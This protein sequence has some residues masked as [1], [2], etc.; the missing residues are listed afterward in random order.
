MAV[1]SSGVIG[2]GRESQQPAGTSRGRSPT[3]HVHGSSSQGL[4]DQEITTTVTHASSDVKQKGW[5]ISSTRSGQSR[6]R[7]RGRSSSKRPQP[8]VQ[9]SSNPKTTPA[10]S[11]A[12]VARL[13]AKGYNLSYIPPTFVDNK[14]IVRLSE[15]AMEASNP[16]WNEYLVGY[17]V[18]RTLPYRITENSLKFTWGPKL[19]EVLAD[20]QEFYYFHIPDPTFRRKI[21]EDGPLTVA[22]VP[23]ILKQWKP[24]ME[25]KK[26]KQESIPVW[27]RLKNL[28]F[29]LWSAHSISAIA[30]VVGKPLYVDERTEQRK[31]ISFARVCV[32]LHAG[33]PSC[34]SV[35]VVLEGVVRTIAIVYEWKPMECGRCGCFGHNCDAPPPNIRAGRPVQ[36]SQNAPPST[37]AGPSHA[38]DPTP[39]VQSHVPVLVVDPKE[40]QHEI[41]QVLQSPVEAEVEVVPHQD[42]NEVKG[43]KKKKKKKKTA[44]PKEGS[45]SLHNSSGD[46]GIQ[47]AAKTSASGKP[48]PPVSSRK[49]SK[50][51]TTPLKVVL[52]LFSPEPTNSRPFE[53]QVRGAE[54]DVSSSYEDEDLLEVD[55]SSRAASKRVVTMQDKLLTLLPDPPPATT[56]I[57]S[58][59][60]RRKPPKPR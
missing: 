23:L 46:E 22:R 57:V 40:Q 37:G 10:R 32:E 17:Y 1:V 30:S 55:T 14:P 43:K 38:P 16:V 52:P 28:P 3:S 20:D 54:S 47:C 42:W 4:P 27:I 26:E 6:G 35:D 53:Q 48:E 49:P 13:A 34:N 9:Q 8:P 12:S 50:G 11:W 21:L 36:R 56:P 29:E 33:Q 60:A 39:P 15:E 45:T 25:L 2:P 31:M 19:V 44:P 5:M 41:E 58:D 59:S 7:S 18:G 51:M 24:L